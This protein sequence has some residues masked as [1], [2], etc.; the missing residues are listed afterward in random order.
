MKM[1]AGPSEGIRAESTTTGSLNT[2]NL[3]AS[4]DVVCGYPKSCTNPKIDLKN[5]YE[6]Q[7]A[8]A[9][10]KRVL[11]KIYTRALVL[12]EATTQESSIKMAS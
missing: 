10:L 8:W 12:K 1:A 11:I 7:H 3:S 5:I 4:V 6:S 9:L 2:K